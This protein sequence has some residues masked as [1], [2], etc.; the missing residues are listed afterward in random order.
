L[1]SLIIPEII[2][3]FLNCCLK[4]YVD[5]N[6]TSQGTLPIHPY[7]VSIFFA[8]CISLDQRLNFSLTWDSH[9]RQFIY[10]HYFIIMIPCRSIQSFYHPHKFHMISWDQIFLDIKIITPHL[11]REKHMIRMIIKGMF[12]YQSIPCY[13]LFKTFLRTDSSYFKFSRILHG[14]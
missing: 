2:Y 7:T 8:V 5:C 13:R 4:F 12:E 3:D 14:I 6:M 1:W 9:F 10:R 11:S